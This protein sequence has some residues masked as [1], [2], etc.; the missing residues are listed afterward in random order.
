VHINGRGARSYA[1]LHVFCVL[2]KV[3]HHSNFNVELYTRVE[4]SVLYRTVECDSRDDARS[5]NL[6]F[7]L[8]SFRGVAQKLP[9]FY[10]I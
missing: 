10:I 6:K 8:T 1:V 4:N 3:T 9:V 7:C 2:T 5:G